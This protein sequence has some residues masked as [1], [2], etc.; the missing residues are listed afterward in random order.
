VLPYD[1]YLSKLVPYLQYLEM[2]RNG[3]AASMGMGMDGHAGEYGAAP[4]VSG[5]PGTSAQHAYAQ[6]LRHGNALVPCDFIGFCQTLNPLPRNPSY[7]ANQQDV[8]MA[9]MLAQ[10]EAMAFGETPGE[11]AKGIPEHEISPHVARGNQPSNT[12]LARRLTPETFGALIALYERRAF[13]QRAI[14]AVDT[15]DLGGEAPG[16]ARARRILSALESES[17]SGTR[18]DSSTGALIAWYHRHRVGKGTA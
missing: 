1:Q 15:V 5:S 2:E 12:I 18:H 8:L 3:H 14:W 7:P 16:A 17:A 6:F 4:V 13:V 11:A 9:N 10:I